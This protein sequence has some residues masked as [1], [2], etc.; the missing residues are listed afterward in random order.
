MKT[1]KTFLI[2]VA[3]VC[4]AVDETCMVF[5]QLYRKRGIIYMDGIGFNKFC[6]FFCANTVQATVPAMYPKKL[7]NK[8]IN[9]RNS[10]WFLPCLF[11]SLLGG[12]HDLLALFSHSWF[13]SWKLYGSDTTTTLKKSPTQHP[14]IQLNARFQEELHFLGWIAD[15]KENFFFRKSCCSA[16]WKRFWPVKEIINKN[17][18]VFLYFFLYLDEFPDS[19]VS[20]VGPLQKY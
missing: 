7:K 12:G 4:L 3:S 1:Q 14:T 16:V 5:E 17:T 9:C 6:R 10:W 15:L 2:L 20:I 11:P 13:Y 8:R 18:F 19:L